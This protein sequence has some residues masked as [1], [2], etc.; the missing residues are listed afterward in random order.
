[1]TGEPC[2]ASAVQAALP[3]ALRRRR[4][5]AAGVD[6]AQPLA[7]PLPR[8]NLFFHYCLIAAPP[9]PKRRLSL[10]HT[11][12]GW[13]AAL[14]AG[15]PTLLPAA[16]LAFP[17]LQRR[18]QN[19]WHGDDP[20]GDEIREVYATGMERALE[21]VEKAASVFPRVRRVRIEG[22]FKVGPPGRTTAVML[23]PRRCSPPCHYV[24]QPS[25]V[26]AMLHNLP[27]GVRW[28][29][30]DVQPLAGPLFPALARFR[31][32]DELTIHGSAAGIRCDV[33]PA[34]ALAPRLREVCLDYRTAPVEEEGGYVF[35]ST[36]SALPWSVL[37][38]LA[39][40]SA[41]HS[42]ELR[43]TWDENVAE[44]C[45]SLPGLQTLRSGGLRSC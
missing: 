26:V 42:L 27:A 25:V 20:T 36:L 33:G 7:A 14:E 31:Q 38:A 18:P 39:A 8:S 23:C 4:S 11:C 24:L 29:E 3:A 35:A 17:P 45:C 12:S 15:P 13:F 44:L 21:M 10:M 16:V 6:A 2:G 9:P 30:L 34:A 5:K 19:F 37:H 32:L 28:L 43:L 40:A 41:L 22:K 1:M